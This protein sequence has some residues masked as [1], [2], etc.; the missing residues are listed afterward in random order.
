VTS[1]N[2]TLPSNQLFVMFIHYPDAQIQRRYFN[3]AKVLEAWQR[4]MKV[5]KT[6]GAIVKFDTF[7]MA[8]LPAGV[9]ITE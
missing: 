1:V 6:V 4:T 8:W 3:S 2:H 7:G 5:L 9:V